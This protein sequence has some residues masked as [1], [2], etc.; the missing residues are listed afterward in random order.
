[1]FGPK[2]TPKPKSLSAILDIFTTA[3]IEL[4]E[5]KG[6]TEKELKELEVTK[7]TKSTELEAATIALQQISTIVPTAK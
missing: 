4:T 3:K 1:M 5:F 6:T 2:N 7:A